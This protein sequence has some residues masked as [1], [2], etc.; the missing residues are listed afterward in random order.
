MIDYLEN[1]F[2]TFN[3]L[4]S[5]SDYID[6][7]DDLVEEYVTNKYGDG[8]GV[9]QEDISDLTYSQIYDDD[10]ILPAGTTKFNELKYF[11]SFTQFTGNNNNGV[12]LLNLCKDTLTEID[13]RNIRS[14]DKESFGYNDNSGELVFALEKINNTENITYVG[15]WAFKNCSLKNVNFINGSTIAE[16]AFARNSKLKTAYINGSLTEVSPYL[17]EWCTELES[18]SGFSNVTKIENGAFS[19]CTKLSTIDIPIQN[20]TRFGWHW[21]YNSYNYDFP[22][23]I[24]FTR[25]VDVDGAAFAHCNVKFNPKTMAPNL[26]NPGLDSLFSGNTGV[27]IVELDYITRRIDTGE[28]CFEYCTNLTKV[29]LPTNQ[30]SY[31]IPNY[32]FRG[33]TKLEYV[34]LTSECIKI[35]WDAFTNCSSLKSIGDISGVK[36][37]NGE[38]FYNAKLN[39]FTNGLVFDNVEI[40]NNKDI[41]RGSQLPSTVSFPKLVNNSS[42]GTFT[43]ATG[44]EYFSAPLLKVLG[45]TS[46]LRCYSLKTVSV[47]S[48]TTI[49]Y[50]CFASC[51][52]LITVGDL[53]TV[54]SCSNA[55]ELFYDCRNFEGDNGVVDLS[56]CTFGDGWWTG[57]FYNCAKIEKVKIG[58]MSNWFTQAWHGWGGERRTF[59]NCTSL[60]TIDIKYLPKIGI[61][62]W[63]CG[64]TPNL[65][66]FVIRNTDAA[67][68]SDSII[69]R[70][71]FDLSTPPN[72][73]VADNLLQTY[74]TD[75][76]WVNLADVIF[77]LSQYVEI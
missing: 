23:N 47:P 19:T 49:N 13:L 6:F 62:G 66:N 32:M 56:N 44:I 73:Y 17:F 68:T 11:T 14:I 30:A 21:I 20:V 18:V 15:K 57:T 60:H 35:G 40:L 22:Q 41:F 45:S 10:F 27:D 55:G 3:V 74:K 1:L 43:D 25:L 75:P 46:F 71:M 63:F 42:T 34:N 38:A 16:G 5:V 51:Y 37:I 26:R 8:I 64:N 76:H 59:G 65:Q 33:C 67:P 54:T 58:T 72:I 53:S 2:P 9:I 36:E 69:Y 48:L 70:D 52:A 39:F 50:D 28:A 31:N 12:K 4:V 61:G 7:E 77:P 24:I 29:V